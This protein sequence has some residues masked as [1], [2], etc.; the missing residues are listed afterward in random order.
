MFISVTDNASA[1]TLVTS[2][3]SSL[4]FDT[5]SHDA[6][7]E[8]VIDSFDHWSNPANGHLAPTS[9]TG[10]VTGEVAA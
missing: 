4:G 8:L 10:L 2:L 9:A 6:R 7:L 1:V 5:R 3:L